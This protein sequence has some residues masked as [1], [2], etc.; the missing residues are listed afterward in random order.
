MH[1]YDK[2]MRGSTSVFLPKAPIFAVLFIAVKLPG[3]KYNIYKK[4]AFTKVQITVKKF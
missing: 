2:K 4:P 1:F 3:N